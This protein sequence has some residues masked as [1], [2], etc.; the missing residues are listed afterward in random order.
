[1]SVSAPASVASGERL[2]PSRLRLFR[3]IMIAGL[4]VLLALAVVAAELGARFYERHRTT[5]P[6]YF[7][8]MYYP[9]QRLRYGLVPGL[10]YYGWFRINSLGFRG[11]EASV[12]KKPGVL[13]VVC[14]GASTTFDIGSIGAARPWPEVMQ[15]EIRRR[16]GAD[17]VEVLN[18]AIPGFTSLDSLIDLQIRV[19]ALQPDLV[20]V[21]QG[22][23]DFIY[24][25]PSPYPQRSSLYPQ[26]STPRSAFMRWIVNHSVLY[27]KSERPVRQ[28]ISGLWHKVKDG[29]GAKVPQADADAR[30]DQSLEHGLAEFRSN[31]TSIA[32]IARANDIP[33][34]LPKIVLPFPDDA[35]TNCSVCGRLSTVFGNLEPSRVKAMFQRYD[36]V[37]VQLAAA[38]GDIHYIPTDGFVPKEDRYYHD[39]I[40][41][42]TEGSKLMGERMGAALA[43]ILSELRRPP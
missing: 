3:W 34:V 8:Q 31:L 39:P 24:S 16:L 7:P 28:A 2:D 33:L 17:S 41:F 25:F 11:P 40:H 29:F 23:N 18:L 19:L 36:S 20:V 30:R 12:A 37:L 32:A 5:P 10:D 42:G 13:R 22:H 43:P 15:E 6:D 21:Y 26:E 38:G 14:L 27:A 9:H 35:P 4:V 1:M